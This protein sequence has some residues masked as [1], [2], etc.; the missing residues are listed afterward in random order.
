MAKQ[1]SASILAQIASKV[2]RPST[3][4]TIN[5]VSRK[6]YLKEYKVSADR[7]FGTNSL[8]VVLY[9]DGDIFSPGGSY[10]INIGDEVELAGY[11]TGDST[12]FEQF[13]GVVTQ[14]PRTKSGKER[15]IQ[16]VC[17]DY[18]CKLKD[19]DVDV[20][21]EAPKVEIKNE[22]LV[23]VRL[24]APNENYAQ[25]FNFA[26]TGIASNPL[27]VL[28]IL[29]KVNSTYY[30]RNSN[31]FQFY[32]DVGQLRLG[33]PLEV[34]NNYEV[35][36]RSY[37][38]YPEGLYIEDAIEDLL[39][40]PDGYGK[41]L[42]GEESA[43]AVIANHLTTDI[44]TAYGSSTDVL[45]SNTSETTIIIKHHSTAAVSEGAI[46]ITLDSVEGLPTAGEGTINGR[47][48]YWTGISGTTLTGIPHE[49]TYSIK[50]YAAGAVVRFED[51]YNKGQVWYLRYNNVV[52]N[53][54]E[55]DFTLPSGVGIKYFDKRFGRIILDSTISSSSVVSCNTNYE[56]KT[57]QASGV[58][59]NKISLLSREVSNRFEALNK[60]RQYAPPNYTVRTEGNEKI[61]ASLLSQKTVADYSLD[62]VESLKYSEDEEIATRVA[63]YGKNN[64]PTNIMYEVGTEFLTTGNDFLATANATTL[65]YEK[66]VDDYRQYK[67]LISDAGYIS[68]ESGIKPT[69][70][71]N[72][73]AVDNKI[74]VMSMQSVK[75][76]VVEHV[77]VKSGWKGL[78]PYTKV[79]TW[80]ESY[81]Y[82]EHP[83]VEPTKEITLYDATG[84]LVMTVPAMASY[85]NY[86][87]GVLNAGAAGLSHE[88]VQ[89]IA[90]ATYSVFYAANS[91]SI[92]YN[93]VKF[94]IHKSLIPNVDKVV[95]AATF[96]YWAVFVPID[97]IGALKDGRWDTEFQ[98]EF[99]SEPPSGY[100]LAILDLGAEYPIQAIDLTGGFFRPDQ[101]TKINTDMKLTLKY[102]L[103]GTNFFSISD[104]TENFALGSGESVNFEEADIGTGLTARYFALDIEN[105]NKI[106]Y[107]TGCW[108]V[109][110]VELAV[111]SNVVV[112]S[113]ITLIPTTYTTATFVPCSAGYEIKV[114]STE[115]FDTPASAE[116]A[117]AYIRNSDGDFVEFTY[118]GKTD[119]KFTGCS[120]IAGTF[121]CGSAVIKELETATTLYDF[122]ELLPKL[123]DK[124]YK[125]DR[126]GDDSIY[127]QTSLDSLAKS[128]LY[129]LTKN[130]TKLEAVVPYAPHIQVGDTVYV[131]DVQE[132]YFVEGVQNSNGKATLTLARYPAG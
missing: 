22:L 31:E 58:E 55:A 123:G 38:V 113:N 29:D 25:L 109:S 103:D 78:K 18:I 36:A 86:E 9:N 84:N 54:T 92:D 128:W 30:D 1:L 2:I 125:D 42:F 68:L 97:G 45:K 11:Y 56:F 102:S 65:E 95:V 59:I 69:I 64:N 6:N 20:V 121:P 44:L 8:E 82:F 12:K 79:T 126:T 26:N 33:F 23:P 27:P 132:N 37:F 34:A 74:H 41:Y 7:N 129:E 14:R 104:K 127:S 62:M 50:A 96:E 61:W 81:I 49:G 13:F 101:Y 51:D 48:F 21:L 85:M 39:T 66:D 91:V 75:Y 116:E 32:Y 19:W 73:V 43:A 70:Y 28:S 4:F 5:G 72:N 118:T 114:K 83:S 119:T 107:K 89:T 110:L 93:N 112:K 67:C 122:N 99:Y 80:Y 108:V 111:Y 24:P 46:S 3:T 52:T 10:E 120:F 15:T 106:D 130:H 76:K 35:R 60:I 90:S 63:M 124:V 57:L 117:T 131:P 100:R 40:E 17:L 87:A 53:L 47:A 16:I 98:A 77:D 105:L 71:I 88:T 94:K 115:G